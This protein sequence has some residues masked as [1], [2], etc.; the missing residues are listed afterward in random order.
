MAVPDV[1]SAEPNSADD[2]LT[3][4]AGILGRAKAAAP[5]L[6]ARAEEIERARHLPSDV[7]DLLRSTGV[8]RMAV[9]RAR[10]GPEL[11]SA[12]QTEVIEALSYGDPSAGWCAMIGMDTPLYAAFL[13]ESA[14]GAMFADPDL[15]TAGLILPA[16]RAERVPGGYRVSGRWP[17]GSGI[18]HA[19]WV[20]A[21]CFVTRGGE[22]ETGPGGAPVWRVVLVRP[23][24]VEVLDT[25]HTTGL[26]GSGSRDYVIGD[27]FVP[28][29]HSFSFGTPLSRTGPLATPDA[30]VRNMPGVPLGLARAALD[31]TREQVRTRVDRATG[32]RWA[33]NYRVQVAIGE[34]EL[35]FQTARHAVYGSLDRQWELLESGKAPHDFTTDERISTALPRLNAFRAARRIVTRLY[36]LLAT[37]SIYQPSPLDRWLR[38]ITTM[39][40]HVVAQDKVIQSAGAHVL[41]GTPLF[42]FALGI[43]D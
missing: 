1:R 34:A 36:D 2:G 25:W 28:E 15:I 41:G 20:S 27:V 35:E 6:R 39:C 9:A 43:V 14:V 31:H 11:T 4:A 37:T 40:Q 12:Q 10:G 42:P 26:R 38:D 17:F 24:E 13:T 30:F 18:T 8:F 3:T 16:G 23:D 33:D 29:E 7:V 32:E 5:L 19:D 22:P 21:G